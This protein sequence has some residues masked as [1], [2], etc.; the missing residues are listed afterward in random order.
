M[1][2]KMIMFTDAMTG[3]A[4]VVNPM[5]CEFICDSESAVVITPNGRYAMPV[6]HLAYLLDEKEGAGIKLVAI[7]EEEK[8]EKEIEQTA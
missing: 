5:N 8:K 3:K 6:N 4:V 7:K 1:S 2:M